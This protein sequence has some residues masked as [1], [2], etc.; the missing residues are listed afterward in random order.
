M[1][2]KEINSAIEPF[3]IFLKKQ[4]IKIQEIKDLLA[5]QA[6]VAGSIES[7]IESMIA[8]WY[9]E[10]FNLCVRMV[11]L[12]KKHADRKDLI[13]RNFK[14][15]VEAL[16]KEA[17]SEITDVYNNKILKQSVHPNTLV[18]FLD[19]STHIKRDLDTVLKE[20]WEI[21]QDP[22]RSCS[23]RNN[24]EAHIKKALDHVINGPS[25]VQEVLNCFEEKNSK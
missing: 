1:E 19:L 10:E 6:V 24:V 17:S 11:G 22:K 18:R 25:F 20:Y 2:T 5:S 15:K 12:Y 4:L 23:M 9:N 16:L 14:N 7:Q 13:D 3:V 8:H 21:A